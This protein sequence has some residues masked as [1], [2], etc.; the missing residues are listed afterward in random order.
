MAWVTS[1]S[2]AAHGV[3]EIVADAVVVAHAHGMRT[4]TQHGP[5]PA[6]TAIRVMAAGD[7]L[8]ADNGHSFGCGSGKRL[9]NEMFRPDATM[10]E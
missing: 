2:M 7:R 5:E 1:S 8:T 3:G 6:R 9:P 4:R 10:R